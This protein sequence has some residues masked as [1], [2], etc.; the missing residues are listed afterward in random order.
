M[1]HGPFCTE[2]GEERKWLVMVRLFAA[3]QVFLRVLVEGFLT[4]KA[5]KIVG[6]ALVLRLAARGGGVDVHTAYGISNSICHVS[7]FE[8]D[9]VR[10]Q[11][12]EQAQ[13]GA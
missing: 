7:S 3:P 13:D 8:I 10:R 4:A 6:L 1:K 5:A 2:K 12:A 11:A 9:Y